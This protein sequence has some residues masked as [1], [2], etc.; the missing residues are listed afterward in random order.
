MNSTIALAHQLCKQPAEIAAFPSFIPQIVLAETS[1]HFAR[2]SSGIPLG[3]LERRAIGRNYDR[4][5]GICGRSHCGLDR[6][7]YM[8]FGE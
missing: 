6:V 3:P 8:S 4:A 2:F 1:E 5:F 7:S